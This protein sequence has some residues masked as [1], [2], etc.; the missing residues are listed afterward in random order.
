[1]EFPEGVGFKLKKTF[2]GKGMDMFWNDTFFSLLD[3]WA[4]VDF[5][6]KI[7]ASKKV[8]NARENNF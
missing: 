7:N 8:L 5:L 1:M 2:H 6:E 3:Q 4:S